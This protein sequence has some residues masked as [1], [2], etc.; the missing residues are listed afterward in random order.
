MAMYLPYF[1]FGLL[2]L[3][4]VYIV[5]ILCYLK[6]IIISFHFFFIFFFSSTVSPFLPMAFFTRFIGPL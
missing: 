3:V 1:E 5:F 2:L 4:R 6:I